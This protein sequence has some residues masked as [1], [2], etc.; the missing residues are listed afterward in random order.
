MN[1]VPTISAISI[2]LK[3]RGM[4]RE[5]GKNWGSSVGVATKDGATVDAVGGDGLSEREKGTRLNSEYG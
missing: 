1:F 4:R 2:H 5:T 3:F